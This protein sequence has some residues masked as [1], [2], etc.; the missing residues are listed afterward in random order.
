MRHSVSAKNA[1]INQGGIPP[2]AVLLSEASSEGKKIAALMLGALAFNEDNQNAIRKAGGIVLL[3]PLLLPA[4][5]S[6]L[7][8]KEAEIGFKAKPGCYG[9]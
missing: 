4:A 1:I 5:L 3:V 2:L 6:F 8:V 7:P 9:R